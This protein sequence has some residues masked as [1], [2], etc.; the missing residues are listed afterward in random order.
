MATTSILSLP[1]LG[2]WTHK[3]SPRQSSAGPRQISSR[4]VDS[5]G[6]VLALGRVS[7]K[8]SLR[9]QGR[10]FLKKLK[11][12]KLQTPEQPS[13]VS[14]VLAGTV[15]YS[16]CTCLRG[17][18]LL[19][20]SPLPPVTKDLSQKFL[21]LFMVHKPWKQLIIDRKSTRLN[22]SHKHRS[23]MPSSA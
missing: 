2:H 22:S 10:T 19:I 5:G 21:M 4:H 3:C 1:Q 7:L 17:K 14:T 18:A 15:C 11:E 9:L 20:P 13:S 6:W 8:E 12:N 16:P 23:R